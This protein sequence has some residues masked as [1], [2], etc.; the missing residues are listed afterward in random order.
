MTREILEVQL[1]GPLFF[2]RED[3]ERFF[4][5]LYDLPAFLDVEGRG[6]VLHLRLTA[7]VDV[8]T[9]EQLLVI[10]HRWKIDNAPLAPLKLGAVADHI[11]WRA[12]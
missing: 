6:C 8:D 7:P 1:E 2:A 9:V 3:E 11:L 12:D 10:C 4:N 5:W